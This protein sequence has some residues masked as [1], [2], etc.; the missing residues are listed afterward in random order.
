MRGHSEPHGASASRCILRY[1][2]R[3]LTLDQLERATALICALEV[4]RRQ[5]P[6][7]LGDERF[8]VGLWV[9]NSATANTMKQVRTE[10]V[11]YQAASAHLAGSAR[12]MPVVQNETRERRLRAPAHEDEGRARRRPLRER[13]VRVRTHTPTGCP[14]YS[15][16]SRSTASCRASSSP[17]STSS[18]CCRGAARPA[19]CSAAR[20]REGGRSSAR[21]TSIPE[22]QPSCPTGCAARAHRAGRAAPDFRTARHHGR[23]VRD[24]HRRAVHAPDGEGSAQDPRV[25]R[26]GA[27]R[28]EQIQAL[29]SR[30]TPHFPP[31]ASTIPRPS[32]RWIAKPRAGSTS[33]WR[34]RAMDEG[35]SAPHLRR[36]L[37]A[38]ASLSKRATRSPPTPT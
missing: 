8:A 32:S 28:R 13:R 11:D 24:G 15:S 6:Q 3:L 36:L 18:R 16:T 34:A 14:W 37:S 12:T 25:H 29:Y 31:P 10:L 9:G 5:R 22:A 27:P 19:C 7:L 17:P 21:S 20:T 35:D 4:L 1:T 38:A 30:E 23:P 2:L 33:G 26:H